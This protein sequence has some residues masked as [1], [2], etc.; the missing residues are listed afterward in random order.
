MDYK[1]LIPDFSVIA[2]TDWAKPHIDTKDKNWLILVGAALLMVIFVFLPWQT[3]TVGKVSS[4]TLG[5]A[6]WYG[7]LGL[8]SALVA[9]YGILYKHI[10]FV[11][12]GAALAAVLGLMGMFL[13]TSCAYEGTTLTADQ[14]KE[15]VKK[16]IDKEMGETVKASISH[17]G[18]ILFLLVSLALAAVSFLQIKKEN[19]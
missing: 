2:K 8:L 12:C 14:V 18:A 13:T 7:I 17:I 6:T 16:G 11:F 19:E 5:V 3:L 4:S 15:F 10:Q 9:V 1:K